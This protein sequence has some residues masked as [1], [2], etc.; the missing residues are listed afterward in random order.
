MWPNSIYHRFV[1]LSTSIYHWLRGQT[2]YT[3]GCVANLHIQ[4]VW[5]NSIYH[6]FIVWPNSIYHRLCGQIYH[7]FVV[8]STS[9]YHRLCSQT[10]YTKVVWLNSIY[11]RVCGQPPD[12]YR[13]CVFHQ[14]PVCTT[15]KTMISSC[16]PIT[17][18]IYNTIYS[19]WWN[20]AESSPY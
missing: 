12:P 3:I 9:I 19:L 18:I 20:H 4:F 10:P 13:L 14:N 7:R 11:Y 6:R 15:R 17:V 5:P 1:V 2:P 16:S 8:W